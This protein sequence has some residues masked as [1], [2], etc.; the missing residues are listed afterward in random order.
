MLVNSY[1]AGFVSTR[2]DNPGAQA[3]KG[4][5][6]G[7][8]RWHS[9]LTYDKELASESSREEP[10]LACAI[11]KSLIDVDTML[12]TCSQPNIMELVNNEDQQAG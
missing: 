1:Q 7:K 2:M 6:K 4:T 3:G 9:V 11:L 10:V 8:V 12:Q 5:V